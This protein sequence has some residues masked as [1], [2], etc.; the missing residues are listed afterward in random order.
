MTEVIKLEDGDSTPILY[1]FYDDQYEYNDLARP[2]FSQ[3]D[4][5]I[6][7]LK[8]GDKYQKEIKD[9]VYN[10][11]SGIKD[12]S[13]KFSDGRFDV[14]RGGY[15]ND[16]DKNKD[17][18]GWAASY[19][20][21]KM[22]KS[23]KYT[24]P[25][26]ATEKWKDTSLS[27]AFV[28]GFFGT[29]GP[30]ADAF[31]GL[32]YNNKNEDGTLKTTG[33]ATAVADWIKNNILD[34]NTIFDRY[35]DMSTE[36]REAQKSLAKGAYDAL[37][38]DS[39]SPDDLIALGRAFP[40]VP[41][42]ELFITSP[43]KSGEEGNEG[44]SPAKTIED[45]NEFYN[46]TWGRK[47]GD[48]KAI[49]LAANFPSYGKWTYNQILSAVD[50]LDYQ[51]LLNYYGTALDNP[52]ADFGSD[53][54]FARATGQTRPIIP[55]HF[56]AQAITS[57][58]LREGRLKKDPDN[59]D[60]MYIP[61]LF[62]PNTNSGYYYNT[63]TNTIH[64]THAGDIPYWQDRL[65]QSYLGKDYQPWMSRYSQYFT[66]YKK[67]GGILKF[68]GGGSPRGVQ[69]SSNYDYFGTILDPTLTKIVEGIDKYGSGYVDW[70]NGMQDKHYNIWSK[71]GSNY[72]NEGWTDP[73]SLVKSY[74]DEY[75]AGYNNEWKN[76]PG[77]YNTLGISKA[78]KAGMF[79]MDGTRTSGDWENSGW[80]SDNIFS[81]ITDARRLLGREGDFSGEQ[82]AALR[83]LFARYN[84]EL[85][86]D[87]TTHYYK[88]R[89]VEKSPVSKL[90]NISLDVNIPTKEE[91]LDKQDLS[92]RLDMRTLNDKDAKT[93]VVPN[94]AETGGSQPQYYNRFL[95]IMQD[96]T[97]DFI[98][99]GVLASGIL[100]NNKRSHILDKSL[101]PV[102]KDTYEKYSP[103]IG[104]FGEMMFRNRLGAGIRS[105]ANRPF[106]SDADRHLAGQFTA[107]DKA[108]EQQYQGFLADNNRIIQR[109]DL[110][111]QAI[112][113][114]MAR[115]SAVANDNRASINQTNREKAQL[116]AA[117][118]KL[119][120]ESWNNFM[121]EMSNRIRANNEQLASLR[122]YTS[123]QA[124]ATQYEQTLWALNK[125]YKEA[126]PDATQSTML[127]DPEYTD[128]LSALKKRYQYDLSN[129]A[130]GKYLKNPYG[131]NIPDDYNTILSTY[132]KH[133]GVLN[134]DIVNLTHKIVH[135]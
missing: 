75:K 3:L 61:D 92:T 91:T 29:G 14:S 27:E 134:T 15:Q 10:L 118:L 77:G 81:S 46:S 122:R 85:Y 53:P 55:G 76:T 106:T 18:Y 96:L 8:Y 7:T 25:E 131:T 67:E 115:R 52:D 63:K 23:K 133:G 89:Y 113:D 101:T 65:F 93:K 94:S 86:Q 36:D 112:W 100:S 4:S 127:A 66:Q 35:P 108:M 119:N 109:N 107:N 5:Y 88:L 132:F 32:D 17:V 135:K 82:E 69:K 47:E 130:V 70:L 24:K 111:L 21:N 124:A 120:N 117:R 87:P 121:K 12:G 57:R 62:D 2:V 51:A 30:N 41:W 54:T 45:F 71:A 104:A 26:K 126:H 39:F 59:N 28:K 83:H 13:I 38:K 19:I 114:N 95:N 84:L 68:Q 60:I 58:L 16:T 79:K 110:K 11:M 123:Q 37:T 102:L 80:K 34:E 43:K 128:A 78:A 99:A 125:R 20:F 56:L 6:S 90:K 98:N 74:Q 129:I 33:R 64:K 72:E 31:V 44:K 48:T 22:G 1:N 97:P 42:S 103:V 50:D 40:G 9:A 49:S 116:E 105:Y 73:N